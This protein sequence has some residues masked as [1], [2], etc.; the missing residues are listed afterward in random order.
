[1]RTTCL[2]LAM[3]T[4][5][6]LKAQE[7]P[8]Q[9]R[10][11]VLYKH[12]VGYF[13]REGEVE[14]DRSI[15]LSFRSA[16]MKDL[17]KSLFAVDLSGGRIASVVYDTRDPLSKQLED[18][19]I[20][21]PREQ[22]LTEFL[23]GLQGASLRLELGSESLQ[24][25][26]MGIEPRK[27]EVEN[28]VITTYE[29][30][31]LTEDGQIRPVPLERLS[32]LRL[33][34]DEL[35]GD[36]QRVLDIHRRSKH[37]DRKS[38]VLEARGEGT[39]RVRVGYIIETPMWKTTYRLHFDEQEEPL[40]QGYAIVE[41]TTDEDWKDV[42][43]TFVAGSPISFVMDLY[44]AYYPERPEVPMQ[45]VAAPPP[46]DP[47]AEGERRRAPAGRRLRAAQGRAGEQGAKEKDAGHAM[48]FLAERLEKTVEPATRGV[49]VGELFAYQAKH[50]VDV[51]RRQAVM[52]P[53]LSQRLPEAGRVLFY[54]RRVSSLPMNACRLRNTTDLTLEAGPVSFFDR[55]TSI[56]E[57]LLPRVL[58][59][60]MVQILPY[61]MEGGV[62]V[63]K[64]VERRGEPVSR[65][66]VVGG[67]LVLVSSR[68]QE[69]VYRVRNELNEAHTLYLDHPRSANYRLMQPPSP[70]A[71]VE[72]HLRF[73]MELEPE[74]TRELKVVESTPVT[75]KVVLGDADPRTIRFHLQQPYLTKEVHDFLARLLEIREQIHAIEARRA[76]LDEERNRL[77]QDQDRLRKHLS[78]LRESPEELDLRK[79]YLQQLKRHEDRI[80]EIGDTLRSSAED[81]EVLRRK[82]S[83]AVRSYGK[84]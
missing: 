80:Q 28:G 61:A 73:R 56:G 64:R 22:A 34:D 52:V 78:V 69:T 12:G 58:K 83:Q 75:S 76:R 27:S 39:R 50:P 7:Q 44:T 59:P 38:V 4:T 17:L 10:R 5:P 84:E 26:L 35:Q 20:S 68:R 77:M 65:A 45:V 82:L 71:E 41:N 53:I 37:S 24:A 16:Q 81:L 33:A 1:M 3:L 46:A 48:G 36:L 79:Q 6:L 49:Q 60:G 63:D 23:K 66:R 55:E 19:L 18:I 29:L 40:L 11:I 70:H 62:Q 42:E 74:A 14:G 32:S 31:I 25:R 47:V 9:I 8:L 43:L 54:R 51:N 13:E 57:G 72:G 67:T 15:R 2:I 30:V 21:V